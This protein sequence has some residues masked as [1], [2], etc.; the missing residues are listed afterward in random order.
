MKNLLPP[1]IHPPKWKHEAC[2]TT[3]MRN[4]SSTKLDTKCT[5]LHFDISR[6]RKVIY[7]T[8]RD[9]KWWIVYYIMNIAKY[10]HSVCF[11]GDESLENLLLKYD[12]IRC[13]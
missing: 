1:L 8:L 9:N 7:Y 3:V 4:P 13:G 6:R 12:T 11:G 5:I 10:S 2:H